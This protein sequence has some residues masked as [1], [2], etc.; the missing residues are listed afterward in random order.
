MLGPNRVIAKD[1]KS[2]T[3]CQMHDIKSMSRGEP[4][5]PKQAQLSTMHSWDFQTKVV[6]SKVW[7]SA[8]ILI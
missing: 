4:L 7:L 2:C 6:Q 3:Y 5:G 8:I 1:V